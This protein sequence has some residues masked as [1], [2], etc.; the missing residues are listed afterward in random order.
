MNVGFLVDSTFGTLKLITI[1]QCFSMPNVII[2]FIF[3]AEDE[4][5]QNSTADYQTK[6]EAPALGNP[7]LTATNVNTD[8]NLSKSLVKDDGKSSVGQKPKELQFQDQVNAQDRIKVT[9][10]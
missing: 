6:I 2:S 1:V 8:R 10:F 9:P 7:K 4:Y 5:K 3:A